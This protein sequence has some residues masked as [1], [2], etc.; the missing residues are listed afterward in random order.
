[1]TLFWAEGGSS[2][3]VG[4]CVL[5]KLDAADRVKDFISKIDTLAKQ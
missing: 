5:F 2:A 3:S 4:H 1:M